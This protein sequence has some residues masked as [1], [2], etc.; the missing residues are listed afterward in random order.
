[1]VKTCLD[2]REDPA[3]LAYLAE[4]AKTQSDGCT[5]VPDFHLDC[6]WA[7]DYAYQTGLDPYQHFKGFVVP[8]SKAKTDSTFRRCI[9]RES[10][11]GCL[12][13]MSW[14]RWGGVRLGGRGVWSKKT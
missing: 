14:W 11:F 9:Q 12:S 2:P 4:W 7:H 10:V 6:C 13:P 8:V 3:Y 1:M 5:N